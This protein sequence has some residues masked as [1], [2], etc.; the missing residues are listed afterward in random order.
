MVTRSAG[1][2]GASTTGCLVSLLLFVGLLYYG[3]NVGE[4]W[5]RYYQFVDEMKTQAR[6][7]PALDDMTIRRRLQAKA[8]SLGLP[9]R[10][11]QIYIARHQSPREIRIEAVYSETI[12]LPLLHHTF[13]FTPRARQPL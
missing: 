7:A 6:L 8:Q 12:D 13:Q 5:F 2:R 4:V 9:E 11:Q 3:I 10:A 1:R